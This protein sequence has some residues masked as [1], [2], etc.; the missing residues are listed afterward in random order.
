MPEYVVHTLMDGMNM[1]GKALN[2]S[3]IM[4]LGMAYKNDIDDLR[5][6]PAFDVYNLLEDRGAT[7]CYHDPYCPSFKR[8]GGEVESM[9]LTAELL[10]SLDAV[11]ITTAHSNVDYQFVVD[12]AKLVIDSRNATKT[13]NNT[14]GKVLRMGGGRVLDN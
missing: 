12:N 7:V 13:L 5:E 6:S 9:P 14:E 1:H 11:V 10:Q 3:N 4:V 8:D 2:G